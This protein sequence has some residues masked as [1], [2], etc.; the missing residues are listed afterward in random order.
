MQL[1][2]VLEISK[3]LGVCQPTIY[4][5][6]REGKIPAYRIGRKV[7]LNFDEVLEAMRQGGEK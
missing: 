6:I 1:Q 2:T 4:T 3:K 7:L 5:Q